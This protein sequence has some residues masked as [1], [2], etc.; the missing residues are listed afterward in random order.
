MLS[1]FRHYYERFP[2]LFRQIDLTRFNKIATQRINSRWQVDK[3]ALWL[4]ESPTYLSK[5]APPVLGICRFFIFIYIN[6]DNVFHFKTFLC[7]NE[8]FHISC[9]HCF[10]ANATPCS[11]VLLS[12]LTKKKYF[13]QYFHMLNVKPELLFITFCTN[14]HLVTLC[15]LISILAAVQCGALW[16]FLECVVTRYVAQC[17]YLIV[18]K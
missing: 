7:E 11:L 10:F 13:C 17:C 1:M 16:V 4:I 9:L 15:T 5:C 18:Y 14:T 12:S 3:E 8:N 2:P 6:T